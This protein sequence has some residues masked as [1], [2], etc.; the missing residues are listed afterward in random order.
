MKLLILTVSAGAG[1]I[2]A[3]EALKETCQQ[4]F[5]NICCESYDVAT[6]TPGFFKLL[7]VDSY[8]FMANHT[9]T[10]WG[11][12]YNMLD[13]E[14][15]NLSRGIS[16]L[17]DNIAYQR[18]FR[19]VNNF[20]PDF[21]LATHFVPVQMLVNKFA[22]KRNRFP[23]GLVITDYYPHAFWINKKC[24]VFF[25]ASEEIKWYLNSRYRIQ[26][27]RIVV[28]GIPVKSAFTENK[29]RAEL[30]KKFGLKE[31][32]KTVLLL[33]GGYG[34]LSVGNALER[35]LSF[36]DFQ[37]IVIAGANENLRKKFEQIAERS[38]GRVK[39]FGFV[40]NMHEFMDVADFTVTK[41][42]GLTVV[43][44]LTKELPMVLLSVVPGQEDKN[45]DFLLEEG[46]AVKVSNLDMLEYK[47][48]ELLQN[49]KKLLY[50]KQNARRIKRPRAAYEIIENISKRY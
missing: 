24:D 30:I 33:C 6:L 35:L 14:P 10:L 5:P 1:H 8:H 21:I 41:P 46:A 23:I 12:L 31:G 15:S 42:G 37:I 3:A 44:C 9:P 39:V 17:F 25:V 38:N 47:I 20:N 27:D 13:K 22:T 4:H 18:F 7:T 36:Q 16:R 40:N 45:C 29:N 50:M 49:D 2:K 48:R 43:E 34:N 28:T 32:A 26:Q 11:I 19:F